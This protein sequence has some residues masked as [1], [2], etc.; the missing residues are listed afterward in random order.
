MLWI[1]RFIASNK[2]QFTNALLTEVCWMAGPLKL[3]TKFED[4][5]G[6]AM[7]NY[8]CQAVRKWRLGLGQYFGQKSIHLKINDQITYVETMQRLSYMML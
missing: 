4:I 7:P 3:K 6:L 8:Y 5:L 2:T 1:L